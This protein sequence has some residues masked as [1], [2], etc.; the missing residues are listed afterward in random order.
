[1][2]V[3]HHKRNAHK[4]HQKKHVVVESDSD[5]D[6]Q[7]L[8]NEKLSKLETFHQVMEQHYKET[9]GGDDYHAHGNPFPGE[10]KSDT[11]SYALESLV[12]RP[13]YEDF[14]PQTHSK[15]KLQT[16][17]IAE[18]DIPEDLRLAKH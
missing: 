9:L 11:K 5:D 14:L 12:Q 15:K 2:Q 4:S 6:R 1:V 7:E 17:G 8:L 18:S 10:E 3:K 13:S 16:W